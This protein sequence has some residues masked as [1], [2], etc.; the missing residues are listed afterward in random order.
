ML[1]GRF[2]GFNRSLFWQEQMC[3]SMSTERWWND[4]DSMERW[5]NDTDSMERW[6]NDNDSMERWWN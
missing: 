4:T 5:W 3:R 1:F 6:W 2:P